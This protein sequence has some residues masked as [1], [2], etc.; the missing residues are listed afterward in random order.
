MQD[1]AP[2]LAMEKPTSKPS[3]SSFIYFSR[4]SKLPN[5]ISLVHKL[6]HG[7]F[8]LQFKGMGDSLDKM[9]HRYADTL[10]EEMIIVKACKS[11]SI[12]VSVPVL[13]LADT[14]R[15]CIKQGIEKGRELL[16]WFIEQKIVINYD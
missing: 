4:N 3:A 7:Y 12:R 6:T 13:S 1:I 14:V 10:E 11:A 2:E 5:D 8:D 15:L 9:H 16:Q